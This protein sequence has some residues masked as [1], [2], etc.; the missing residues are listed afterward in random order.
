M[1]ISP[2]GAEFFHADGWTDMTKRIVAFHNFAKAHK[3]V[4]QRVSTS[5][6]FVILHCNSAA[7]ISVVAG[8]QK[9]FAIMNHKPNTGHRHHC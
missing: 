5:F 3:N 8:T 6:P 1:K 4:L 2:V 7:L 9:S